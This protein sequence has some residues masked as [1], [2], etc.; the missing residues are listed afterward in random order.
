MSGTMRQRFFIGISIALAALT[1]SLGA[2]SPACAQV[3]R[4]DHADLIKD[5]PVYCWQDLQHQP[6]AVVI[7]VHGLTMHGGV[8][9][10]MA[11]RLASEGT[12]VIAPDMRGYGRWMQENQF[13]NNV[14]DAS[15]VDYDRSYDDLVGL[16]KSTKERYP[17][18][19]LFCVGESLGADMVLHV[20]GDMP[21]LINGIVLSAPAIK[22]RS[23][24]VPLV[25]HTGYFLANPNRRVDLVPY[26]KKLASDD[27]QVAAGAVDDPLVRKRLT[28]FELLRTM[29]AVKP[30]LDYAKRIP[31]QMP[32]L[33]IQGSAD[34]VVHSHAVIDLL[35]DLKSDDQTVKW[36]TN[37]GHLLLE[38]SYIRQ[39]TL[40]TVNNWLFQHVRKTELVQAEAQTAR[41]QY[42]LQQI[43]AQ[44]D[45]VSD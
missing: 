37:R 11:R 34:K 21:T 28:T 8:F 31:K 43:G 39:D 41:M 33:V 1:A 30:A 26:I 45:T 7:A 42:D 23:F 3:Q 15:A 5:V 27:P 12:I 14:K 16:I 9:D 10:T 2:I 24:I 29:L 19:P 13:T 44:P 38:T 32:V 25:E 40:E 6:R 35:T 22:H 18:L 17:N 4:D 36:F 20:A